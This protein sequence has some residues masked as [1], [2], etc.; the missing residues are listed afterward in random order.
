MKNAAKATKQLY[1]NMLDLGY[2]VIV[3]ALKEGEVVDKMQ[4]ISKL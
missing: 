2:Q 1:A 4:S 3:K